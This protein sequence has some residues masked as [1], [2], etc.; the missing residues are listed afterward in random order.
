[1]INLVKLLSVKHGDVVMQA[2]YESVRAEIKDR[3]MEEELSKEF[4][5]WV[6]QLRS[7]AYIQELL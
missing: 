2:P 1:M 3:L 4:D 6:K 7:E 5:A